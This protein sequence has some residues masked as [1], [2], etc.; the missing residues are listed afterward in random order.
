[1]SN[2]T[3][4]PDSN[5]VYVDR[6]A[7]TVD[8][9]GLPTFIHAIQWYGEGKP[10]PYGEIEFNADDTG[11]RFPNLRFTDFTPFQYLVNAWHAVPPPETTNPDLAD[12]KTAG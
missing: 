12:A 2:Y 11:K 6:Q 4:T 9:S 5:A 10:V 3:I 7:H 1:M 8:C